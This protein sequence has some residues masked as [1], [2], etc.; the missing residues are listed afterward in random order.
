[1]VKGE[2][3]S[4]GDGG[5]IATAGG[6]IFAAS[7]ND[8]W[9]RAYDSKTG[10]ELWSGRLPVPSNATPMTYSVKGKQYVVIA[11]GGHGFIGKGQSDEVIAYAL[12]IKKR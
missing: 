2:S 3:G 10:T 4:I 12:P 6:L 5:V 9:L 1:M 8:P 7:T 11:A